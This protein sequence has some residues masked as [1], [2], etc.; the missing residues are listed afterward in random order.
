MTPLAMAR[1][2]AGRGW[3]VFPVHS[4]RDGSCTCGRSSCDNMA[5]HPRTEHG[6]KDASLSEPVI[7]AWWSRWPVANVAIATGA[8]SGLLVLDIDPRHDGD[9]SLY[10]FERQHGPLPETVENLT[11]GGGRHLLFAHPGVHVPNRVGLALGLDVRGDGGFIVAPPSLHATGKRYA[12]AIGCGPDDTPLAEAPGWLLKRLC[13]G[14]TDGAARSTD[15][16]VALV[17]DGADAGQRNDAVARLAGYLLRR[18][19]APRVVLELVRAWSES[20]CRPQ[21]PHDEITKTV[22]S[23]AR[24]EAARRRG[25]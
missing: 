7:R 17:R 18:R 2:Y 22:D 10:D 1:T 12:W 20:R 25:K 5:K 4:I 9:H 21:L 16:W 11:G 15:E 23:I 13:R 8:P 3:P 6:V 14:Q 19:P 24:K